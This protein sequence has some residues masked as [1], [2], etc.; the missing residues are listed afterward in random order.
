MPAPEVLP[1]GSWPT[2]ITAARVVEAAVRLGG[3]RADGTDLWWL[4]LRPQEGGRT[5]LVRHRADGTVQELVGAP[6]NVR[7]AVHEYG[8]GAAWFRDGVAWFTD[9][10]DQRLSRFEPGGEPVPITPE[11]A[12]PRGLRYADGDVSPDGTTI[13]C[14]RERHDA[15]GTVTNEIV[16]MPVLG[17]DIDVTV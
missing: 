3:L 5:A 9:W 13:A 12:V 4:E 1:Y 16:V 10:T 6:R 17:G 8:G 2:P 11:P 15:D 7:T 14:V